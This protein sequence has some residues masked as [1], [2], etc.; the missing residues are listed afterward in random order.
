MIYDDHVHLVDKTVST[1][2]DS[3]I[4]KNGITFKDYGLTQIM[5]QKLEKV[6]DAM[7]MCWNLDHKPMFEKYCTG[8][9][10]SVQT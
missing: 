10:V 9:K 4:F 6:S 2:Y 8:R 3:G 1:Y 5:T 7:I